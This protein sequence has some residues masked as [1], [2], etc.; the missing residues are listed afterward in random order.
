MQHASQ[1]LFTKEC[2]PL[3]FS[4]REIHPETKPQMIFFQPV[5]STPKKVKKLSLKITFTL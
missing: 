3:L 1:P 5:I 2:T 4:N